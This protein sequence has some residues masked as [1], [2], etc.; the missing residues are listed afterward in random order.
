MLLKF[1]YTHVADNLVGVRLLHVRQPSD[2]DVIDIT[3]SSMP[4]DIP[5][6]RAFQNA[7]IQIGSSTIL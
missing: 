5:M 6:I 1:G 4:R 7:S 3:I 2:A